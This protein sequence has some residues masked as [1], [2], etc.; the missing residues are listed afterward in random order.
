MQPVEEMRR[1]QV[2]HSNLGHLFLPETNQLAES[3][4]LLLRAELRSILGRK[5]SSASNRSF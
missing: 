2:G 4:M 3:A 5:E 1:E